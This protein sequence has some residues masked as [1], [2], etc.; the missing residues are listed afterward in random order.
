MRATT[1]LLFVLFVTIAM[2]QK[3]EDANSKWTALYDSV[4]NSVTDSAGNYLILIADKHAKVDASMKREIDS[5]LAIINFA[6]KEDKGVAI[7]SAKG[8]EILYKNSYKGEW[9]KPKSP[10]QLDMGNVV[11]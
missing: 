11:K 10:I 4:G 7:F 1:T 6:N 2:A 9:I 8:K 3:P 5:W